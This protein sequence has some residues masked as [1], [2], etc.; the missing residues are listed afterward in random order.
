MLNSKVSID[1]KRAAIIAAVALLAMGVLAPIAFF[2]VLEPIQATG[3]TVAQINLLQASEAMFRISILIF[4]VVAVLDIVLAWALHGFFS[5]A[6]SHLSLLAAWF[7]LV[8]TAALLFATAS[9]VEVLS[10]LQAPAPNSPEWRLLVQ[11]TFNGFFTVFNFGLG[12]FGFHLI[13]LGYLIIR[14]NLLPS[15]LGALVVI[16]GLGYLIDTLGS[17]LLAQYGLNIA[18]ITFIGEV[19]LIGWLLWWGLKRAIRADDARRE[20]TS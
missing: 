13:V 8:Y 12:I 7:R 15:L 4:F 6:N 17:V 19:L 14:T 16:A 10:L 5:P 11:H 2:V 9:L 18:S 1:Q 3:D 20:A